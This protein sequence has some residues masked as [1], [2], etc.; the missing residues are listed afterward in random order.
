MFFCDWNNGISYHFMHNP[1]SYRFYHFIQE[2]P[3]ILLYVDDL[4]DNELI[5][6]VLIITFMV[7][8][9]FHQV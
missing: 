9:C 1:L 4:V 3:I 8:S 5:S 7:N 6:S 2:L